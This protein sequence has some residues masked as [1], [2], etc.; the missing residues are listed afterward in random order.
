MEV[1]EDLKIGR[2]FQLSLI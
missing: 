2:L 1:R